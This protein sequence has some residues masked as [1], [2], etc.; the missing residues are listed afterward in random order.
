MIG[1]EHLACVIGVEPLLGALA[2]WHRDQ[3]V[4]V[5]ADHAGLAA[6]LAHPLQAPELLLGLLA[7]RV[8]HASLLDLGAVLLHNRGVVVAELLADRLHLLAQD[9]LALLAL[10]ARLDVVADPPADLKLGEALALEAEGELEPLD[11]VDGLEELDLLLEGDLRRVGHGV[12]EGA[13]LGDRA[14]EGRDAA[15]VAAQLEDLLDDGAVL[16]LELARAGGRRL[17]VGALVDLHAEPAA[18]VGVRRAGDAAVQADERDGTAP[19]GQADALGDLG[20]GAHLGVCVLVLRDEQHALLVA[21]VDRQGHV[22]VREDDDVFQ[23]DE[24]EGGQQSSSGRT[25]IVASTIEPKS[26]FPTPLIASPRAGDA[27]AAGVRQRAQPRLPARA[28]GARRG[29]RLLGLARAD[30][31]AGGKADA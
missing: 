26:G 22:H 18:R 14:D 12:G 5:A 7:H 19:A 3:P 11:D 30:A 20:D 6:L 13:D 1:I 4:E 23:R 28:A 8:G 25:G 15:V 17:L 29:R 31:R 2:P 21:D 27:H 9:V 10:G 24:Q 16:A